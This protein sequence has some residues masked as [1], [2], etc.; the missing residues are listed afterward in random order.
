MLCWAYA[1]AFC[2]RYQCHRFKGGDYSCAR[3][4]LL[5][6][7]QSIRLR[8]AWTRATQPA[9]SLARLRCEVFF[10]YPVRRQ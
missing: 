6:R 2:H 8:F 9:K 3:L 4:P 10:K 1:A 5:E 7:R